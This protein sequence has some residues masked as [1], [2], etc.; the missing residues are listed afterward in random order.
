M[1][2]TKVKRNPARLSQV[3]ADVLRKNAVEQLE[4]EWDFKD[5]CL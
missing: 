2:P 5:H 1:E 4:F 3:S